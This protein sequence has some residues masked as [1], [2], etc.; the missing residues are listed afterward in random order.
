MSKLTKWQEILTSTSSEQQ[1]ESTSSM[2]NEEVGKCP[3]CKEVM[4]TALVEGNTVFYCV[5]HRIALPI[6]NAQQ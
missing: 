1:E 5:K 2:Y 6:P 4:E 3:K